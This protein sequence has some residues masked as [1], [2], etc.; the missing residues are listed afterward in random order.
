MILR[1]P[2][3]AY[4]LRLR[5]EGIGF[6]LGWEAAILIAR[7]RLDRRAEVPLTEGTDAVLARIVAQDFEA[8]LDLIES[9]AGGAAISLFLALRTPNTVEANLHQND[10]IGRCELCAAAPPA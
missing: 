3:A 8:F 7:G 10:A 4:T 2:R 1:S 9:G 6:W 5:D